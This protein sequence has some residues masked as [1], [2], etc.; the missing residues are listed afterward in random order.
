[1][2]TFKER[3]KASSQTKGKLQKALDKST[4]AAMKTTVKNIINDLD[5]L[6]W[7][8]DNQIDL[9]ASNINSVFP[10]I[11]KID[12]IIKNVKSLEKDLKKIL[13]V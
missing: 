13:K 12:E 1:M 8:L 5:N 9:D 3:A 10:V 7:K 11:K 2:M 4:A 6:A